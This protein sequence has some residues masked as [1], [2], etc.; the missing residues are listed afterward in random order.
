MQ[1]PMAAP[2][3]K[4]E[5]SAS[6]PVSPPQLTEQ[7]FELFRGLFLRVCGIRLAETKRLLVQNRVGKRLRALGLTS[8]T[9]YYQYVRTPDGQKK[10]LSNL[11][12]AITTNQTHFFR[13][14]HH[15]QILETQILPEVLQRKPRGQPLRI[16]SAGCSTGR[17]PYTLAMVLDHWLDGKQPGYRIVGSDIDYEVLATAQAG[18]YP[19]ES[20]K[21]LR[22]PYLTKYTELVDGQLLIKPEIKKRV[23]FRRENLADLQPARPR[24]DVIFCRNVIMYLHPET[25]GQLAEVFFDSLLSGGYLIVGS[26][27]SFRERPGLFKTRQFGRT[28]TYQRPLPTERSTPHV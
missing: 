5:S 14:I 4:P 16:W 24:F 18:R 13:E 23:S 1:A 3:P 11:L 21:E 8:F 6:G 15:F 22:N 7:E 27:E 9:R 17:E 12:N 2:S 26:S 25:R 10:E 20:L 19:Q 28:L